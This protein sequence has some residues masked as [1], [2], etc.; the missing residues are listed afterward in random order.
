MAIHEVNWGV[1]WLRDTCKLELQ[2]KVIDDA[3]GRRVVERYTPIGVGVGIVPWNGP[4][5]LVCIL[6]GSH[7]FGSI[8]IPDKP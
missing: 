6:S 1:E 5:I 2:D 4:V 7:I 8:S 3:P